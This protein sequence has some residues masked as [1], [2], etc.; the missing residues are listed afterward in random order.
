MKLL[1]IIGTRPE[2]I[3]LAPLILEVA[4]NPSFNYRVCLSGQHREM[5]QPVL[6]FFGIAPDENR[7]LMQAEQ[8]SVAFTAR[9]IP[10]LT[11]SILSYQPDWVL[12][13]GDTNTALA[14]AMAAFYAKTTIGHIEAG[15]RTADKHNPYPEE[16]NRRLITQLAD[17]HFAPTASARENLIRENIASD[18]IFVTGNTG[19]DA[20]L[21]GIERLQTSMPSQAVL[22]VRHAIEQLSY[23]EYPLLLVTLHRQENRGERLAHICQQLQQFAERENARIVFPVH[24]NPDVAAIVHR[25]LAG[26]KRL[27][28]L[29]HQPYD[30]FLW[31]MQQAFV[32]LTD[33]GGI[34]E[35]APVLGKPIVVL[36]T[37]TER[38]ELM[39]QGSGILI[40]ENLEEMPLILQELLQ[41]RTNY[42]TKTAQRYLFG[43]GKASER[44]LEILGKWA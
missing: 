12:V 20:L 25:Y 32:I 7:E 44:I 37:L 17:L 39:E 40:G 5:V 41:H 6:D 13:Q 1:F 30:A 29:P 38:R 3:K 31:L 22:A 23:P 18:R 34:Q 11:Q 35:E 19:I 27:L 42:R 2:A 4:K 33:S 28:L 16:M 36:R 43:D 15:L 26:K 24:P 14:G 9:A 10:A 21:L 8:A